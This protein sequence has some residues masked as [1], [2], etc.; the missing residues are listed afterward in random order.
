MSPV[1]TG[2]ARFITTP[3]RGP[4][5]LYVGFT[6]PHNPDVLS[7]LAAD[8]R[9]TPG[10]LWAA[11]RS[12]V[13]PKRQD[14]CRAAGVSAGSLL[15]STDDKAP[16]W[17]QPLSMERGVTAAPRFGHRHYPLALAWMDS[18]VGE[19]LRVLKESA[20]DASTLTIFTSDHAAYDKGHCYTGGSRIPMMMSWPAATVG[21]VQPAGGLGASSG[22]AAGRRQ[23]YQRGY[24][25]GHQGG[26]Q[27]PLPHLVSH[28][29]LLPTL[30]QLVESP[31]AQIGAAPAK[32]SPSEALATG[33]ATPPV[34]MAATGA[35]AVLAVS[36]KDYVRV[37]A[38]VDAREDRTEEFASGGVTSA[39]AADG[40]NHS[41]AA[42]AAAAAIDTVDTVDTT[43]V[44]TTA[45]DTT[46]TDATATDA[47][48]I[49]EARTFQPPPS[50]RSGRSL[51]PLL[52]AASRGELHANSS[53][54]QAGWAHGTPHARALF[55]EVGRSRAVFTSRYRLIY[56]P[57]VKPLSKGGT[58][59]P[60]HNYQSHRHHAAYWR[61][62]QLYDLHSDAAEQHNL[63][64][65]V[66]RAALNLSS[67]D[68]RGLMA[69]LRR[70]QDGLRE[71]LDPPNAAR[72]CAA[73]PG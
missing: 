71:H 29:D 17:R 46:A 56:S 37:I 13:L 15:A 47:T 1:W 10:G 43:E 26:Y 72:E 42:A 60:A 59:D 69:D 57:R 36:A 63:I 39:A 64:L 66:E 51:A 40:G 23:G 38:T 61:P 49:A 5:F 9:Y 32:Q 62:L 2:A 16:G 21:E 55:C 18:G 33:T 54:W 20:L 45:V 27:R 19:L 14:V 11:N 24:Q 35:A 52:A 73:L 3:R 53:A 22:I 7:S 6:L 58:T 8:P 34:A 68:E 12:S 67:A 44:D 30:L 48:P 70:L 50:Y 4:F 25:G 41:A 65:P 28:L 31:L